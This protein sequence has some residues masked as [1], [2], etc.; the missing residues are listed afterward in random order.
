MYLV[1]VRLVPSKTFFLRG[2]TIDPTRSP[3]L[4][5]IS[6]SLTPGPGR[7]RGRSVQALFATP[8]SHRE[9]LG[10]EVRDSPR[11][12]ECEEEYHGEYDEFLEDEDEYEEDQGSYG[13]I[14]LGP[15]P[16]RERSTLRDP[17][18]V[19][20]GEYDSYYD[21]DSSISDS[22]IIDLP[23]THLSP[24]EFDSVGGGLAGIAAG[25]A[26]AAGAAVDIA[27]GAGELVRR[28][29]SARFLGRSWA[30]NDSAGESGW[31]YGTF[32][33]ER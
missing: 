20:S 33:R 18:D 27:S 8:S 9:R 12:E 21:S 14:G 22:S 19:E 10:L 29:A 6:P 4:A 11:I 1:L 2:P 17:R 15:S 3:S 28:S 5:P 23:P 24:L 26:G 32:G 25:V 30:S 13:A 7:R 16:E 31:G